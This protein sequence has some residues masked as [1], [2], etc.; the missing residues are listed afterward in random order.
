MLHGKV[1]SI[2]VLEALVNRQATQLGTKQTTLCAETRWTGSKL[3]GD[4]SVPTEGITKPAVH[5]T[6]ILG[7]CIYQLSLRTENP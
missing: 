2:P 1:T 7:D 5:D 3:M 6:A 4:Y